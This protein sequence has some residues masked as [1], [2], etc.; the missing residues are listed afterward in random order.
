[1]FNSKLNGEKLEFNTRLRRRRFLFVLKRYDITNASIM[2]PL[3]F[4]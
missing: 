4:I 3:R 1:L 2:T